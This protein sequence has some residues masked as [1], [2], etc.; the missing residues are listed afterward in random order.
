MLTINE[1]SIFDFNF[2]RRIT[3]V[4]FLF[5]MS[6]DIKQFLQIW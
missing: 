3:L 2:Q 1:I 5:W 6:T 4:I